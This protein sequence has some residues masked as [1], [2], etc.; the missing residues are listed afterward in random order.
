[1]TAVARYAGLP[2]GWMKGTANTTQG[3]R[4]RSGLHAVACIDRGDR[5]RVF[6]D[7]VNT[8]S[9]ISRDLFEVNRAN[10]LMAEKDIK[11]AVGCCWT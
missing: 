3:S 7:M 9:M 2:P 1:M 4:T 10:P 6:G 8:L 11:G 5:K